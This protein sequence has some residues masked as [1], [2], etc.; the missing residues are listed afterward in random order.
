MWSMLQIERLNMEKAELI[1]L[2]KKHAVPIELWGIGEAKTDD[3]LLEE[4]NKHDCKLE[5]RNGILVRIILC[6]EVNIYAR[7]TQAN[8]ASAENFH[9]REVKQVFKDSRVRDRSFKSASM[10]EKRKPYESN[11]LAVQRGLFEELNFND[12]RLYRLSSPVVIRNKLALES[13]CSFPGLTTFIEERAT[14]N[15]TIDPLLFVA[16]GYV[17]EEEKKTTYFEWRKM[18]TIHL[19]ETLVTVAHQ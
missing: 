2:L 5:V 10:S 18:V 13:Y 17:V 8:G 6:V 15:C 7:V 3:D 1:S 9:L 19:P 4:V 11:L 16:S 14:F 12:P